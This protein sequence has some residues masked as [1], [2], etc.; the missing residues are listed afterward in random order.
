MV[1]FKF[2]KII[3]R[4]LI[5]DLSLKFHYLKV[6]FN[7]PKIS[8]A[9]PVNFIYDD[10]KALKIGQQVSIGIFSEVIVLEKTEYSNILGELIIEDR[11]VIGSHA[12]V[13]AAGGCIHIGC[14]TIIGQ[15]VSLIAANHRIDDS[16]PYRDLPWDEKKPAYLLMRM[17]GLALAL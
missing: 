6:L 15:N 17:Y 9:W 1:L 14:N 2:I 4:L 13:R 8:I 7:F 16:L 10:M 5:A 3:L 12:N 11:V